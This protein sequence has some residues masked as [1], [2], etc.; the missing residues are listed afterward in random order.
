MPPK[1]FLE[2]LG[3]AFGLS[4]RNSQVRCAASGVIQ[5]LTWQWKKGFALI[6]PSQYM[7]DQTSGRVHGGMKR[8]IAQLSLSVQVTNPAL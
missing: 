1:R 8:L 6:Q 4:A 7:T 2:A 5:L 3:E